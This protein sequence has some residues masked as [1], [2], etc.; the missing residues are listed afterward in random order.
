MS[1]VCVCMCVYKCV[2]ILY[3]FEGIIEYFREKALFQIK[4]DPTAL[5][6]LLR[7]LL[8]IGL[9]HWQGIWDGWSNRVGGGVARSLCR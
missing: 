4:I 7:V 2:C 6:E 5:K 9:G 3:V 1:G 8:G